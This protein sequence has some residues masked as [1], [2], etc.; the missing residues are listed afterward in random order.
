MT[1]AG[2]EDVRKRYVELAG[3]ETKAR[4]LY[5]RAVDDAYGPVVQV[6]AV[7]AGTDALAAQ[8]D[9]IKAL[10]DVIA[11]D[12]GATAMAKIKVVESA[13]GA[14]A[15]ASPVKSKLS[16]ARRAMKG[17]QPKRDRAAK[18][19]AKGIAALDKELTWRRQ[20]QKQLAA[21]LAA[22]DAAIAQTIGLRSQVR[23]NEEQ[24]ESVA[25]C[26]SVHRDISLS[27]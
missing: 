19:L 11:K 12:D 21:G 17:D 6:R 18:E 8:E 1:P 2:W 16:K 14:V 13:V 25:A 4:R 27:F 5:R 20:A 10:A 3:A 9:A 22:Y 24:A 26:Q 23:L 15:G 7:I